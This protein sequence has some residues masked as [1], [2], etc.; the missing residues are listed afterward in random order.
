M[1][2]ATWGYIMNIISSIVLLMFVAYLGYPWKDVTLAKRI[3][4][5]II[6]LMGITLPTS[7]ILFLLSTLA[8]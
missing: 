2:I 3:G 8:L 1:N 6:I 4:I 5:I 7:A